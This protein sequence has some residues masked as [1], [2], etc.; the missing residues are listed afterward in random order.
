MVTPT[1]KNMISGRLLELQI[2]H[3]HASRPWPRPRISVKQKYVY[4]FNNLHCHSNTGKQQT[5][6]NVRTLHPL[7]LIL[8]NAAALCFLHML[9]GNCS[10]SLFP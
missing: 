4:V 1:H 7:P 5:I 10:H 8:R 9:H 2:Y 6:Q 3:C